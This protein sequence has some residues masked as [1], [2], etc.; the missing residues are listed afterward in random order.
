MDT[1]E[2]KQ[3]IEK[4]AAAIIGNTAEGHGGD[5]SL[6]KLVASYIL[7]QL[8]KEG[9]VEE[10]MEIFM[11]KMLEAI[12]GMPGESKQ[13][14][15]DLR[16]HNVELQEHLGQ[17]QNDLRL[18]A[19][20]V[21]KYAAGLIGEKSI[22]MSNARFETLASQED[23]YD[24]EEKV[25]DVD[26]QAVHDLRLRA[27]RYLEFVWE[28]R[29]GELDYACPK[30]IDAWTDEGSWIYV[31][32]EGEMI[33]NECHVA[34]NGY[35]DEEVAALYQMC[36]MDEESEEGRPPTSRALLQWERRFLYTAQMSKGR[37]E[38]LKR[39]MKKRS[40]NQ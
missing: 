20:D 6:Y 5:P 15:D 2:L 37:Q 28:K 34:G 1:N 10:R 3:E 11:P 27:P 31:D 35:L 21:T 12:K 33:F 8:E 26:W 19:K 30:Q 25:D 9:D 18:L 32:K 16:R 17:A 22:G 14:I 24:L 4:H 36:P 7:L 39:E 13:V 38:D 23:V 29:D 40:K